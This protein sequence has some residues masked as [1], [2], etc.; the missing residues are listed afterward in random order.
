MQFSINLP[1]WLIFVT[2]TTYGIS[3][4]FFELAYN[5][6]YIT[7]KG[8][9]CRKFIQRFFK[10]FLNL[11][12]LNTPKCQ[13]L[14]NNSKSSILFYAVWCKLNAI[15]GI[16]FP[17]QRN[18]LTF[19]K[20][21]KYQVSLGKGAEKNMFQFGQT[22]PLWGAPKKWNMFLSFFAPSNLGHWFPRTLV[23]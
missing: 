11:E 22:P 10:Q 4:F 6:P 15:F 7:R 19:E 16:Q 1:P 9:L 2:I 17:G 13:F 23:P 12:I 14:L 3:V 8:L 5:F 20:R 18:P 21:Y